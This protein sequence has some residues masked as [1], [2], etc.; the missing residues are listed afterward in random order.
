V[1]EEM[2]K[3]RNIYPEFLPVRSRGPTCRR[4]GIS[5]KK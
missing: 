4:Y 2:L 1:K 5:A 3:N